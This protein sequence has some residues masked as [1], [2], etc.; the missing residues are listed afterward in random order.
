MLQRAYL[1]D[2]TYLSFGCMARR[3][4]PFENYLDSSTEKVLDLVAYKLIELAEKQDI[5]FHFNHVLG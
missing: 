4:S 1:V 2:R 3:T 5:P